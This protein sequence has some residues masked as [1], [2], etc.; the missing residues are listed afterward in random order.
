MKFE[1]KLEVKF[2]LKFEVKFELKFEKKL[3]SSNFKVF[4]H[5]KTQTKLA[6]KNSH[7]KQ[8]HEVNRIRLYR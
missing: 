3:I 5:I 7:E 4:D 2:E 8:H 6:C 1:V